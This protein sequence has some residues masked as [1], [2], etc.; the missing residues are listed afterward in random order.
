MSRRTGVEKGSNL[1]LTLIN[2]KQGSTVDLTLFLTPFPYKL[3]FASKFFFFHC[4][5]CWLSSDCA[6]C[7]PSYAETNGGCLELSDY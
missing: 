1:P 2:F 3:A 6:A 4:P 7:A 5:M